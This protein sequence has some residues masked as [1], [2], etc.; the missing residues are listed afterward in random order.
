MR[1]I[2]KLGVLVMFAIYAIAGGMVIGD[3]VIAVLG[4]LR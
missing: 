2:L 1:G 4:H 3:L